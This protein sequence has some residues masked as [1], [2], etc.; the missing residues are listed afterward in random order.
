M[1]HHYNIGPS[2]GTFPPACSAYW[3]ED[4]SHSPATM[5]LFMFLVEKKKKTQR[6]LTLLASN[7]K[8]FHHVRGS[9]YTDRAEMS[10]QLEEME[11]K[12]D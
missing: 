5:S 10:V 3:F 12:H 2:L 1:D 11:E 8:Q 7:V 9:L 6:N 4:F